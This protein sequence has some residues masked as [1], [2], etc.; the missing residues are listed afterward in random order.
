MTLWLESEYEK[1]R[2]GGPRKEGE[3]KS[4]GKQA[5]EKN[6]PKNDNGK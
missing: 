2:K 4:R 1:T 3:L 5:N 6:K